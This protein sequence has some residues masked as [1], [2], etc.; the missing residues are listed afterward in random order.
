MHRWVVEGGPGLR[1]VVW[2]RERR[3]TISSGQ[4]LS[5]KP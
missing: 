3:G 4:A 1:G 2:E 5:L